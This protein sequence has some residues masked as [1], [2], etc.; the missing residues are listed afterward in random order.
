LDLSS[1]AEVRIGWGS[2]IG[3]EGEKVEFTVALPQT[4]ALKQR[5]AN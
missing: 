3:A 4:A 5:P 2:Y 1:V